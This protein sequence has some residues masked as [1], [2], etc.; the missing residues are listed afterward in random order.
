VES[1]GDLTGGKEIFSFGMGEEIER[2]Q[3]AIDL[4]AVGRKVSLVSGGDPGVYGMAGLI[5]QLLTEEQ[6][7]LEVAIVPGIS[8]LNAAASLLGAPL[9]HDFAVISLSDLLTPWGKIEKR[10]QHAAEADFVIVIYNPKSQ[11]RDWQIEKCRDICLQFR[12]SRT[13]VGLVRYKGREEEEVQIC[14][15]ARFCTYPIDMLTTVFIGNSQT[16]VFAKWM[17]TPRGY[18][19]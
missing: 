9:M 12:D 8:A 1:I 2:C 6:Q 3:M 19:I 4:A 18:K 11:A 16:T 10:I 5:L 15:L 14:D 13:P 7:D 17:I